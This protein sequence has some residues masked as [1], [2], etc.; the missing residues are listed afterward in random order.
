M[1]WAEVEQLC[2]KCRQPDSVVPPEFPA[3]V[4]VEG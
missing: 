2:K 3:F 4:A 1:R